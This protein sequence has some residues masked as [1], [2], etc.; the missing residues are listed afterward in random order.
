MEVMENIKKLILK[1]LKKITSKKETNKNCFSFSTTKRAVNADCSLKLSLKTEEQKA[2]IN[3]YLKN[4]IK[5]YSDKPD[6]L[7][8]FARMKGIAIH[9]I[10]NA[11]KLLLYI[12]EKEGFITP[13]KGFNALYLNFITEFFTSKKIKFSFQTKE[14][15]ILNYGKTDIFVLIR[16]LHKYYGYKKRLPGF[17]DKSQKIYKKLYNSPKNLDDNLNNCTLKDMYAC[18]EALARDLESINFTIKLSDEYANA[19]KA[20]QK[21]VET[22][23]IKV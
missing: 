8:Q 4:I 15:I 9:K 6:K 23:S 2:E 10:P 1:T 11:E 14:M 19:K 17:D 7:L 13:L 22:N 3:T 18:K 20:M 12:N 5:K 16:A 21:L